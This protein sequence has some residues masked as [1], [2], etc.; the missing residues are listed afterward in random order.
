[1]SKKALIF[2][3]GGQDGHYLSKLLLGKGCEVAGC[4][5]RPAKAPDGGLEYHVCDITDAA[6][7][8]SL[9]SKV[10]P[11]EAYNLAGISSPSLNERD[12]ALSYA[13]NAQGAKNVIAA[14]QKHAPSCRFFQSSTAYIFAPS[15]SPHGEKDLLGPT[16]AYGKSKLEAH[17]ATTNARKSGLY[18][19]NGILFNHESPLRP[20]GFVTR[21]ITAAAAEFRLGKRIAPLELGNVNAVRDWGFAGDYV[22]AMWLMLQQNEPKDYV[23]ATGAGHTVLDFC[24]VAFSHVGLDYKA[25]TTIQQSLMRKNEVDVL[26]GDPSSIRRDLKWSANTT[27]AELVAMM[28]D[29]DLKEG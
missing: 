14:L 15:S 25:H 27:F 8:E 29:A 16:G 1:M 10:A 12:L 3:V 17:L 7:V 28:V 9:V 6:Q 4:G 22:K 2:G 13:V 23:I 21:K 18:A 11:D 20:V 19:A 24:N 5:V 26:V